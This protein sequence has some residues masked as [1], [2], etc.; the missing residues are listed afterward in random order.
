MA[1]MNLFALAEANDG[2]LAAALEARQTQLGEDHAARVTL[3]CRTVSEQG[4]VSMNMKPW[5]MRAFLH[6]GRYL[7]VYELAVERAA[8]SGKNAEDELR[9]HQRAH[10]ERRVLFDR[11]FDNGERFLYGALNIGGEGV[12][13]GVFCV[14]LD[15]AATPPESTAFVPG[16]SLDRYVKPAAA[17]ALDDAALRCEVATRAQR[18]SVA[19]LKHADE[20][21]SLEPSAWAAM[22]CSGERFVEAIFVGDVTL[23]RIA[24]L[25]LKQDEMR[26]LSDLAFEAMLGTVPAS[27]LGE[28]ED[29][30]SSMSKLKELGVA[31][32]D[33]EG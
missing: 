19:A 21:T 14:V 10:Y 1:A 16:N 6:R 4:S 5:K 11:S 17:L 33:K 2:A 27:D 28:L 3:F 30:Q 31:V 25:R 24:E 32:K 12:D 9:E 26:R 20:I 22:L 29:F 8:T 18:H 23:E 13:Y 15:E 7:S